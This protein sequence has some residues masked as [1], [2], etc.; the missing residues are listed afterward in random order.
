MKPPSAQCLRLL[1]VAGAMI[2]G[3]KLGVT[4][5]LYL[6]DLR[7]VAEQGTQGMQ[8]PATLSFQIPSSTECEEYTGKVTALIAGSF[9]EFATKGCEDRADEPF[10]VESYL[11][12]NASLP[13]LRTREAFLKQESIFGIVTEAKPQENSILVAMVLNLDRFEALNRRVQ[14]EFFQELELKNSVL[15]FTISNDGRDEDSFLVAGSFVNA[16][17]AADVREFKLS[18][19]QKADIRLSDVQVAHLARHGQVSLLRL[20]ME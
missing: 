5:D 10:M 8:V 12:A 14:G 13:L 20:R 19:R 18:R 3:C 2:A 16:E 4:P 1:L 15:E 17:P 9:S 6:T 7:E 11:M